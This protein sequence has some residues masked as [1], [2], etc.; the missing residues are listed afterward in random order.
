M[1]LPQPSLPPL[2]QHP[3]PDAQALTHQMQREF[4]QLHIP[5]KD[6][7]RCGPNVLI[8]LDMEQKWTAETARLDALL[9][10]AYAMKRLERWRKQVRNCMH[11]CQ[12]IQLPRSCMSIVVARIQLE[13]DDENS[14]R[15]WVL[16]P[17]LC[18]RQASVPVLA[19]TPTCAISHVIQILF[20]ANSALAV[21]NPGNPGNPGKPS[22]PIG[23]SHLQH[24]IYRY[25]NG[26]KDMNPMSLQAGE[27]FY[28]SLQ[29]SGRGEHSFV[30]HVRYADL[31]R[32][33]MDTK[34][35]NA[36]WVRYCRPSLQI[37]NPSL[38]EAHSAIGWLRVVSATLIEP[39]PA[40]EVSQ[41][42]VFIGAVNKPSIFKC[43]WTFD[44]SVVNMH[45][46]VAKAANQHAIDGPDVAQLA[47]EQV[48]V[49]I[50]D[51][52]SSS[53]TCQLFLCSAGKAGS[54]ENGNK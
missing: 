5:G 4:A 51:Q 26:K 50:N 14:V 53:W 21:G 27:P 46:L 49:W 47:A 22:L 45:Q 37:E 24:A 35:A 43:W 52:I 25:Q 6:Y 31:H 40:D 11:P 18:S 32:K 36:C 16:I 20:S 41:S 54:A 38:V 1:Q 39:T 34:S 12:R 29:S 33:S 17:E 9:Q 30:L 7:V 13:D 15:I 10:L 8:E 42:L 2:L 28:L 23:P 19:T 48:T 44:H 3:H